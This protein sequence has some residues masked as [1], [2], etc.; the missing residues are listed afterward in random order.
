MAIESQ[1]IKP[2]SLKKVIYELGIEINNLQM[3]SSQQETELKEYRHLVVE[4]DNKIADAEHRC[5]M[6]ENQMQE[7]RDAFE[8]I[9]E[10]KE[11]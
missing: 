10:G 7:M 3:M 8:K 1:I 6:L 9:K 5:E 4:A 11:Q 2:S